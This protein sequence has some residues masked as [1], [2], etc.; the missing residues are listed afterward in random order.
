MPEKRLGQ[1]IVSLFIDESKK[2]KFKRIC[3]IRGTT[4][5]EEIAKFIDDY[6]EENEELLNLI[7]KKIKR[8]K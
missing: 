4:M 3:Q 8:N 6:I 7:D 2:E 5:T 1:Q